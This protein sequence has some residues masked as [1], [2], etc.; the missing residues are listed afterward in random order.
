LLKSTRQQY[1][2]QI[3]QVLEEQFP[4]TK[5]T[6]PELLA[7]HYTEAGLITQAIPYWQQAGRQATLHSAYVEAIAHLTKGL[8]LLKILPDAPERAQQE[9]T[10]QV[11]LGGPLMA[12]KGMAARE[13]EQAYVRALDLCRQTGETPLLFPVL[14]GLC[15]VYVVRA[16]YKTARERGEQLLQ[17]AHHLQDPGRLVPAHHALGATFFSLGELSSAREQFEKGLLLATSIDD[18]LEFSSAGLISERFADF[19]S[20]RLC[21]YW[22]TQI[23]H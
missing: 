7:H 3:A 14:F 17:L 6:Q 20:L 19:T 1:H 12:T 4:E 13:V 16:E 5:E 21:G 15:N 8:E 11:A 9:L 2:Q 10:L 23:R 22:A 18:P